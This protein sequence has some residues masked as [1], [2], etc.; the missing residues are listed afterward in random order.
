MRKNVQDFTEE[1]L[2]AGNRTNLGFVY[3]TPQRTFKTGYFTVSQWSRPA[4]Q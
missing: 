1:K 4:Q 2:T 3:S